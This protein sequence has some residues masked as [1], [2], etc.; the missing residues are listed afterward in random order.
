MITF[1][2]AFIQ[3]D[4]MKRSKEAYK[5]Y[6]DTLASTN[7]SF[8]L[9]LDKRIDWTFPPNVVVYPLSLEECWV[10]SHVPQD[11]ILPELRLDNTREYLMIQNSKP[12]FLWRASQLNVFKTDWFAWIDFGIVHVFN[13]PEQTLQRLCELTPPF[14]P[15]IHTAGIWPHKFT[16]KGGVCWRYAGGFQLLHNDFILPFWNHCQQ[17]ILTKLPYLTWEVNNWADIESVLPLGW[18]PADHNDSIIP[19]KF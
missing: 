19:T 6:F 8:V 7:L 3:G 17:Q 5:Q 15:G 12:E 4:F 13:Q 9:F 2:S 14:I 16:P 11:V 1:V 18:Y 10:S